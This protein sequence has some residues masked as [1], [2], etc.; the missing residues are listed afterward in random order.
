MILTRRYQYLSTLAAFLCWAGIIIPKADAL[1][2]EELSSK[3]DGADRAGKT[4]KIVA[5]MMDIDFRNNIA[6]LT[7][8][9]DVNDPAIHIQCDKMTI[10]LQD[11]EKDEAA[12]S[13]RTAESLSAGLTGN[14]GNKELKKIVCTGHVIIVRQLYG[15]DNQV[16]GEQRATAGNA[17]YD[18]NENMIVLTEDNPTITQLGKGTSTG[19]RITFWPDTERVQI[20]G[21]SA[22]T[23]GGPQA[24]VEVKNLK[25]LKQ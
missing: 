25:D 14:S 22:H 11:K 19:W 1:S 3:A 18:V 8:K 6:T 21:A 15:P 16:K 20:E 17:V 2:L 4:T 7:G 9:V 10:Y 5:D 23:D 12:S 13:H 24:S